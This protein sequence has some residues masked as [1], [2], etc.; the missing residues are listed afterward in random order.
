MSYKRIGFGEANVLVLSLILLL[1]SACVSFADVRL[2]AVI[3]DNMVLQQG[4]KVPIWGWAEPGEEVMVSVNWHSMEWAVTADKDGKWMF[5]MNSPKAGG[6]Y[7]MSIRGKN[8]IM[9][10]NIIVGEV[11]ICSGQS[12]MQWAVKQS[13]NAEQEIAKA[14]YPNI[15]LFTV[16]REVAE[17]PKSDCVG[18][19]TSCSPE[20]IPDFS[21][22]AYYFGRELHR[23]LD[24]PILYLF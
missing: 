23:E 3:G 6:P 1:V 18:S 7:K 8:T 5:V 11:W 20:T 16:K 19:W 9:I 15:R 4:R 21:A 14:D 10:K 22:V 24:V 2:P 13:A 12:N 17:Q